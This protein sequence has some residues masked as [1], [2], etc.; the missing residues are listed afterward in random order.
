MLKIALATQLIVIALK[1]KCV[2]SLPKASDG[3]LGVLNLGMVTA[4][5][6]YLILASFTSEAFG[7]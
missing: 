6:G 5:L 2:H 1:H 4:P 7:K 3:K